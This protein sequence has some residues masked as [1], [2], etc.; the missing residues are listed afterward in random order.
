MTTEVIY[1]PI[2]DDKIHVNLADSPIWDEAYT[3]EE[4]FKGD[5]TWYKYTIKFEGLV[6]I[7]VLNMELC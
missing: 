6:P 1:S 5:F 4:L 2:R 3:E 7:Q